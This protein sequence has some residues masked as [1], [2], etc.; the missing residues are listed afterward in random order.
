MEY[1]LQY[2][3]RDKKH[4]GFVRIY[5]LHFDSYYDLQTHLLRNKLISNKDYKVFKETKIKR[6]NKYARN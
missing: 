4:E 3:K 5:Y 1:V 6:F 2:M